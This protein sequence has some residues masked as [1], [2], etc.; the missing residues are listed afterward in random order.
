MQIGKRSRVELLYEGHTIAALLRLGK[1][2]IAP[3]VANAMLR[4]GCA[5]A[6]RCLSGIVQVDNFTGSMSFL[7][8]I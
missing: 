5:L 3:F 4:Q 2:V 6:S 7:D 8:E 1:I